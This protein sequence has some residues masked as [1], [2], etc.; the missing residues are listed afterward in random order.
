MKKIITRSDLMKRLLAMMMVS[1]MTISQLSCTSSFSDGEE[2]DEVA[3]ETAQLEKDSEQPDAEQPNA[4]NNAEA[5]EEEVDLN[6]SEVAAQETVQQPATDFADEENLDEAFQAENQSE[7]V[8]EPEISE[9]PAYED[10]LSAVD[11]NV[12]VTGLDYK[13]NENGGTIVIQT[14][15]PAKY[16]TQENGANNQYIVEIDNAELPSQFQRPYNTKEF[17]GVVGMINAYQRPGTNKV[18]IIVQLK[19]PTPVSVVQEGNSLVVVPGA[20]VAATPT[21]EISAEA[22]SGA[23]QSSMGGQEVA[24]AEDDG[25]AGERPTALNSKT[26]DEFLMGETKFYGKKISIEIIDG[27]IRDVITFISE[28]SGVNLVLSDEIK[29]KI[30]VKLRQIPWD[31]ALVVIMQTKQLGYIRQGNILRISTLTSIRAETDSAKQLLDAQKQL[32]PLKVKVFPIS[33]AKAKDLEPQ[34]MGFLSTRGS[35][36]A[37]ERTNNLVVRDIA[38]NVNKIEK[39]LTRLDTQTPQVYIEGK[40]VESKTSNAREIGISWTDNSAGAV[41][42]NLATGNVINTGNISLSAKLALLESDDKVKILS[43]P[44]IVTLDNQPA[45]IEQSTQFPTYITTID[46]ETN[47]KTTTV[48]Y[49]TVK[50]SLNVTPQIT[51]DGGVILK[52]EI[53]REFAGAVDTRAPDTGARSL[54]SRSAKSTI[55]VDNGS[56]AV[57]GGIYSTDNTEGNAGIPLL[58]KIPIIGWLFGQDKMTYDKNELLIFLTPR[59]INK[60]KAFNMMS[61]DTDAGSDTL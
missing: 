27:E 26:L 16:T 13:A 50:L 12:R 51:A 1:I 45:N 61:E 20:A 6:E 19:K 42:L 7:Q 53:L 59:V 4:D 31:Q 48:E 11:S 28:E 8:P 55:L 54:N 34:A 22:S 57:L 21:P 23:S 40:I 39:L 18:R 17:S 52:T 58:R 9:T 37:D 56:T 10:E 15:G 36:K 24:V 2:G 33:Y 41:G 38:E 47:E 46:E 35:A 29:G 14:S 49:K 30:S 25:Q 32:E 5:S 43:S 60:D 44:R 3:Q